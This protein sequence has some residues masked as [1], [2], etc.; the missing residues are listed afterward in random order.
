MASEIF[1]SLV[2]ILVVISAC[3]KSKEQCKR[4]RKRL[5][6]SKEAL[7]DESGDGRRQV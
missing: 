5:K 4:R 1:T 2:Y 6:W 7:K 3:F